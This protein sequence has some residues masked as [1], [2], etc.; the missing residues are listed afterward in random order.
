MIR[1]LYIDTSS[2]H[3]EEA[4]FF[5]VESFHSINEVLWYEFASI[6]FSEMM[7]SIKLSEDDKKKIA[8]IN[9]QEEFI[10]LKQAEIP[11]V[12]TGE[13]LNSISTTWEQAQILSKTRNHKFGMSYQINLIE[14]LGHL[15]NFVF[16][17]ETLVNRHLLYLVQSHSIDDFS[18]SSISKV[19]V[20]DRLVFIFKEDLNKNNDYLKEIEN[21][22]NLNKKVVY[23]SLEGA[24][25]FKSKVS[26]MIQIWIDSKK[27]IE[28]FETVENFNEESFSNQLNNHIISFKNKWS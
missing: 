2:K 22:Y 27:I 25:A 14:L 7:E 17:I 26:E 9:F 13:T 16:F 28:R 6:L 21:L 5:L 8:N 3:A 10:N 18:Y 15:N 1:E 24:N 11:E 20:M 23:Y 19:K 4:K 12:L